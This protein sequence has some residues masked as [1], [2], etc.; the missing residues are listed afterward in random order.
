MP[1]HN[2][3]ECEDKRNSHLKEAGSSYTVGFELSLALVMIF[4]V[5]KQIG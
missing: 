5:L 4:T 3:H 1:P 2:D